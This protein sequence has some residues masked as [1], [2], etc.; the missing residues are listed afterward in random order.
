M[1]LI[2]RYIRIIILPN[3]FINNCTRTI[4]NPNNKHIPFFK[5]NGSLNKKCDMVVNTIT[6][7]PNPT[8][9]EGQI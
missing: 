8:N 3:Y 5:S 7:T 9:L 1:Y 6:P 2:Q 4:V